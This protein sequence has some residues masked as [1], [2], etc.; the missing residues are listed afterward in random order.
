VTLQLNNTIGQ[1]LS[2]TLKQAKND[3]LSMKEMK[4][5]KSDHDILSAKVG[6]QREAIDNC[7]QTLKSIYDKV[8][9]K[10]NNEKSLVPFT[11]YRI[12]D[13]N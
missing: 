6:A 12:I 9:I 1:V 2:A 10:A 4:E 7:I 5:K 3:L 8:N 13:A 11:Q